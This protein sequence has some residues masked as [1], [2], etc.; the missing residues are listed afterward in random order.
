MFYTRS[1]ICRPLSRQKFITISPW[2]EQGDLL[3]LIRLNRSL[4]GLGE[5]MDEARCFHALP[6]SRS[7]RRQISVMRHQQ[8]A[9]LPKQRSACFR[10]AAPFP[11]RQ[12][13]LICAPVASPDG[14]TGPALRYHPS[15]YYRE[16][17]D[18]SLE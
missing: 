2:G 11:A 5:A 13:Q 14:S 15:V 9:A 6:C 8:Q 16:T 12:P 7:H 10:L 18:V 17:E 1:S 4:S 3:D